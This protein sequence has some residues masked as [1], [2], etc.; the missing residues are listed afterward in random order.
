MEDKLKI[1]AG[2]HASSTSAI[3]QMADVGRQ[4]AI[5]KQQNKTL[6]SVNLPSGLG[7]KG[8]IEY[9]LDS[10]N[11]KGILK[12]K[13][14]SKKSIIDHVVTCPD[15]Y[16]KSMQPKTT[17][18]GFLMNGM[19]DENVETYPDIFKMLKT[20]KLQDFKKDYEDLLFKN[21]SKLYKCMK[22]TGA[23]PEEIYDRMGFIPDTNFA[24]EKVDKPDTI[25]QEMRH[26]AKISSHH[27][28]RKLRQMKEVAAALA[29]K[30]KADNTLILSNELMKLNDSAFVKLLKDIPQDVVQNEDR[31]QI[32]QDL[33]IDR[34]NKIVI[35]E[36]RALIHVQFWDTSTIPKEDR[37]KMPTKK[38]KFEDAKVGEENNLI[39]LAFESRMLPIKLNRPE[40]DDDG[41]VVLDV[42][43]DDDVMVELN[44]DCDEDVND[45]VDLVEEDEVTPPRL[46]VD[47]IPVVT[48]PHSTSNCSH[49]PSA[50][51]NNP[52]YL[53]LAKD[54]ILGTYNIELLTTTESKRQLADKIGRLLHR[55]LAKHI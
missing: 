4:F 51:L 48:P 30:K 32:I 40:T 19:L 13:L 38:G 9:E 45:I 44:D 18:K 43:N 34:F 16:G 29:V 3:Q 46:I 14:P 6:T 41:N 5:M 7:L 35:K 20:C 22:E 52:E 31:L 21:F 36:L 2:K 24:G 1:L 49:Q 47:C 28:Q 53:K 17:K 26:R 54:N 25:S 55:R 27:L 37:S 42:N 50:F 23:I 8:A 12:L 10:L 33:P 39:R 15:I 11:A